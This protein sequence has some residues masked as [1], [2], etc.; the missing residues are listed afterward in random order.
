MSVDILPVSA[1][2]TRKNGGQVVKAN[3]FKDVRVRF[4]FENQVITGRRASGA[5]YLMMRVPLG[6]LPIYVRY[7]QQVINGFLPNE[8]VEFSYDD[9]WRASGN[10]GFNGGDW[11]EGGDGNFDDLFP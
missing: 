3:E 10:P 1:R 4:H 7:D 9:G 5:N 11:Y 2:S 8:Y 6:V